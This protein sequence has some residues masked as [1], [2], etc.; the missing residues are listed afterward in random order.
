MFL[1]IYWSGKFADEAPGK[2]AAYSAIAGAVMAMAIAWQLAKTAMKGNP[3]AWAGA[4]V[5]GMAIGY[6]FHKM[7]RKMME[8]PDMSELG[9]DMDA[10]LPGAT[11]TADVGQAGYSAYDTGGFIYAD[12]GLASSGR[13]RM[14]GVEPG[15]QIISRTGVME[16]GGGGITVNMGDV[17]A[18]DGTDFAQKLA[19]E[20][21]YALRIQ[22]DIGGV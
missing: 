3:W 20:L 10:G 18:Q 2:A 1:I 22:S 15:E 5:A 8:K 11:K 6:A 19:E 16:G 21:P 12:T 9:F 13:H 17:Y 7:M 4:A 14:V